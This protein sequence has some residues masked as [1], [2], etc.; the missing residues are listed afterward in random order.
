[1]VSV[2]LPISSKL[3]VVKLWSQGRHVDFP[4]C[5]GVGAP[6]PCVVQRSSVDPP[7]NLSPLIPIAPFNWDY[8]DC[9]VLPGPLA[10]R[11]FLL[12]ALLLSTSTKYLMLITVTTSSLA[13]VSSRHHGA[14]IRA[15]HTAGSPRHHVAF[16]GYHSS[17]QSVNSGAGLSGLNPTSATCH[18]YNVGQVIESLCASISSLVEKK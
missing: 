1:M 4:L 2:R 10:R 3:F 8:P 18:L 12:G 9:Q 5:R 14:T 11:P 16:V 15:R 6:N 13:A 7:P 17:H